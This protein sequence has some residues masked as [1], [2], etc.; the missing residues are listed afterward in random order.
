MNND[1]NLNTPDIEFT[2][3]DKITEIVASDRISAV[4]SL[5]G[6]EDYLRDHFP[7]F[8]VMPG[9]LMLEA[10]FQA[11]CWLIRYS[12]QFLQSN[13]D[14]REAK[15]IKFQ[16]FVTPG[17]QLEVRSKILKQDGC[18]YSLKT[19]CQIDGSVAVSGR[20]LVETYN[21]NERNP[22]TQSV[23]RIVALEKQKQFALLYQSSY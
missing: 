23:D 4:K 3:L 5:T 11:S 13:V 22:S 19:E 2:Q 7:N 17:K 15:S 8:S 21:Q 12:N 16:D 9:V 20:L 10:M 6:D 14:L 1:S 18:Q